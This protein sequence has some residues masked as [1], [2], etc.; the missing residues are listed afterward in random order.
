MEGLGALSA[1]VATPSLVTRPADLQIEWRVD[2]TIVA[3]CDVGQRLLA[4]WAC[5]FGNGTTRRRLLI[6]RT[7]GTNKVYVEDEAAVKLGDNFT[8]VGNGFYGRVTRKNQGDFVWQVRSSLSDEWTTKWV[9]NIADPSLNMTECFAQGSGPAS[10]ATNIT[11]A[12]D[13]LKRWIGVP[14]VGSTA[15]VS[16]A[17]GT[18]TDGAFLEYLD[19]IKPSGLKII[20]QE[21]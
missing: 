12:F 4:G 13:Y 11:V 18:V 9:E 20:F 2:L 5:T 16:F 21:S 1:H 7:T 6:E 3:D 10:P 17:F 8:P 14:V 15:D 19:L